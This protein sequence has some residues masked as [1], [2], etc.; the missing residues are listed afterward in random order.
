LQVSFFLLVSRT[1]NALHIQKLTTALHIKNQF[2]FLLSAD[3]KAFLKS[4]GQPGLF[5]F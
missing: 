5:A 1:K 4:P 2:N 3:F